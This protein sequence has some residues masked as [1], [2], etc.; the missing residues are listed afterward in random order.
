MENVLRRDVGIQS[1]F[2]RGD[3]RSGDEYTVSEVM[4]GLKDGIRYNIRLKEAL[5][6]EG[7][8]ELMLERIKK[9]G[10]E[11]EDLEEEVRRTIS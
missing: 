6:R 1:K 5:E 9:R 7:D 2:T 3:V 10:V 8:R 4:K 11:E